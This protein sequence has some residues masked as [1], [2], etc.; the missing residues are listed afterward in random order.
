MFYTSIFK[1]YTFK[2]NIE[3]IK[4]QINKYLTF[5]NEIKRNK[6]KRYDDDKL[7]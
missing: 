1:N 6:E 3:D 5:G 4:F 7:F 2:E